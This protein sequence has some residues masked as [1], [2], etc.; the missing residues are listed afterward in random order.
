MCASVAES[1]TN[2][3]HYS[4]WKC[5]SEFEVPLVIIFDHRKKELTMKA[6]QIMFINELGDQNTY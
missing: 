2:L 3:S 5:A 4:T 6:F 1:I